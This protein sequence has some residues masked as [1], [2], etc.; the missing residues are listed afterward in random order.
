MIKKLP[1]TCLFTTTLNQDFP[2][3]GVDGVILVFPCS[4]QGA[5]FA[6]LVGDVTAEVASGTG[7][8]PERFA[9]TA[10]T[11]VSSV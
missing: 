10:I 9:A 11:P 7:R 1:T 2:V 6:P 8:A 4:G 3:D 5:K